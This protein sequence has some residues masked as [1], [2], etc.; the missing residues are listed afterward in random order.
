MKY[1]LLSVVLLIC[2]FTFSIAAKSGVMSGSVGAA[3]AV[4][5]EAS[6]GEIIFAQN[7]NKRLPMA[8]TTKIM[9]ALI[10]LEQ[11]DIHS[12]FTVDSEA[13]RTEGSS[14]GLVEGD[15]VNLYAL[16]GG[17]LSASGNDAAN[18]A[19]VKISGS[20]EKFAELMNARARSLGL[21][22][23][24]FK[25]PSGLPDEQHYTTAYELARLAAY[26]MTNS[27]FRALASKQYIQLE[28]GNPP[29]KRSLRNH[30][31]LLSSLKGC[32]GVKTGFTKEA[33]RCLVSAVE[34]DGVMLI[35]VT[36][37][38]SDDW[39]THTYL[40]NGCVGVKT[41]FTK[42]AGRCLV[43][44]VE[45][46]GVMLICVTLNCSDDWSTH[47]YLHNKAFSFVKRA[48]YPDIQKN[49]VRVV[50]G[51]SD[52]VELVL[53]GEIPSTIEIDGTDTKLTVNTYTE[54]FCSAPIH[55]GDVLGYVEYLRNGIVAHTVNLVAKNSVESTA[56]EEISSLEKISD[57]LSDIFT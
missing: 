3:A 22:N 54:P 55:K 50:A 24:N 45:R 19:A 12:Q 34:R 26:A 10:A 35:C 20:I 47:T 21:A 39:S 33:G 18:A 53:E 13:I 57:F 16:A 11:A 48:K 9:S 43:S 7:E 36:L 28:Y 42:E 14:M 37:N 56:V 32:V 44:A 23:T 6:T 31:R 52:M 1:K 5:I 41:G 2:I 8:S 46:D 25:N 27:D 40:H 30:N 49:S 38:C 15:I 51:T 4:V 17:M 29:Y